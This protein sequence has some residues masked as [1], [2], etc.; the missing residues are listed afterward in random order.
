MSAA[1]FACAVLVLVFAIAGALGVLLR[2]DVRWRYVCGAF[3]I[4]VAVLLL[5][6]AGAT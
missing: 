6:L 5:A 1:I 4:G 3:A 2:V